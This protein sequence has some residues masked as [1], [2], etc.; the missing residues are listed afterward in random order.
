MRDKFGFVVI[1][2]I[3]VHPSRF[4][5]GV[6][7]Y[8]VYAESSTY[9]LLSQAF[10]QTG[11]AFNAKCEGNVEIAVDGEVVNEDWFTRDHLEYVEAHEC[12]HSLLNHHEEGASVEMEKEADGLAIE[13][14]KGKGLDGAVRLARGE[15]RNRYG[16]PYRQEELTPRVVTVLRKQ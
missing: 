16:R 6:N 3:S 1:D 11:I 2:G 9:K 7:I 5:P 15:Y 10:A 13:L 12:A 8:I 14:M 4:V